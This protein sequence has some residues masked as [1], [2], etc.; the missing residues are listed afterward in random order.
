VVVHGFFQVGKVRR[1]INAGYGCIGELLLLVLLG[2]DLC[3]KEERRGGR[4]VLS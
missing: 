4:A 2:I 3:V 1:I